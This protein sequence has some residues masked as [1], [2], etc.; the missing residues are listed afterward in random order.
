MTLLVANNG[1]W[2]RVSITL[3]FLAV[4]HSDDRAN[5]D[6]NNFNNTTR[7]AMKLV[8]QIQDK[9]KRHQ[10]RRVSTGLHFV[11]ADSIRYIP[12]QA[13]K[14][15]V[16]HQS[17]FMS[18]EYLNTIE[19]HSPE[20]S[21]QR[22]A[23]AFEQGKPVVA[24][25][26]QVAQINGGNFY[27]PANKL[28]TL[29]AEK[30]QE[31]I[32]VCGNL[33]SSGLHG[34]AFDPELDEDRVWRIVAEMLYKIRRGEQL[35]GTIDF[36][37]L[38]DLKGGQINRSS[39][40][41]RYSYRKI[42]T[43]PDMVLQLDE[44]IQC[45]DDYLASLT[46]KYRSRCK[47]II[48]SVEAAGY[49]CEKLP[50]DPIMDKRLHQL[51]LQVENKSQV[52]LAT[53][54]QGYF[55]ALS[56]ILGDKFCCYGIKTDAHLAGFISI[57]KDGDSAVAYYVGV[58]YQ[59]NKE[60][61]VYFRLLQLVIESAIEMGCQRISFGRTASEPK[62]NLGAKPVDSYV[63]VRHRVP[64]VNFVIRKLFRSV[65]YEEAPERTVIRQEKDD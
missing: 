16:E 11:I 10:E 52:R 49:R 13:W 28:Q 30:Y 23:M 59:V 64:L 26:C 38:K 15:I 22:Y 65:P 14:K 25:V 34:V 40:L 31:R 51:Y 44:T 7:N 17:L 63:W 39:M 56:Q 6:E 48:T 29:V 24:V 36:V 37:M 21:Q 45:F 18:L 20:N 50:V 57:V 19:A 35:G 33:V 58:D 2:G 5:L 42:Q 61:P 60:V 53:L 4:N 54:P 62:A 41:E 3:L 12:Q 47:K 46:S 32:L 55:Y 9:V 1:T 27:K 43:D 8:N